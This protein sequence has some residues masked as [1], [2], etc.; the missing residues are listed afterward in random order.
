MN[1]FLTGATGFVGAEL[2]KSL[3]KD[4]HKNFYI[5]YRSEQKKLM[6]LNKV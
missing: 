4:A 3:A 1:I 6:L 5:L 2:I